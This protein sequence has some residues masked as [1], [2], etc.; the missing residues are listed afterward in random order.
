[1]AFY[2][3]S[4]HTHEIDPNYYQVNSK[5]EFKLPSNTTLLPNMRLGNLGVTA[6]D[7]VASYN[8]F[9]GTDA[10]IQ[11]IGLYDG[12]QL[13]DQCLSANI[14]ACFKNYNRDNNVNASKYRSLN[15]SG[16]GFKVQGQYISATDTYPIMETFIAQPTVNTT[17][18]T[19]KLGYLTLQQLLPFLEKSLYVPTT[20]YK[21]L[22]LVIKFE[23]DQ[24]NI[25]THTNKAPQTVRP[26]LFCNELLGDVVKNLGP[27]K[28]VQWDAVEHD[29]VV[30]P[31]ITGLGD[32]Y[33]EETEDQSITF[34]P[35]GFKN[36]TLK[37]LLM[38]NT[39]TS[40]LVYADQAD[41]TLNR[42][43]GKL[44]SRSQYKQQVQF[45]VNG[46]ALIVGNGI[47]GHNERLGYLHDTFG[48]CSSYP[49]CNQI[50]TYGVHFIN[51][52]EYVACQDYLG[53]AINE[54][55]GDLQ[56]EYK[57]TGIYSGADTRAINAISY[58]NESLNIHL[59]GEVAKA[60]V[61]NN[62]GSY[63]VL[64]V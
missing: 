52:I 11:S 18:S 26:V 63:R 16:R 42:N 53:V 60:V 17:E 44:A 28:G 20:V 49:G 56:I 19:T 8:V 59:F 12:N 27:Y 64:Y 46:R 34:N 51:D 36:K 38:V 57:R 45:V 4:I 7:N 25:L 14:W 32:D 22:K 10:L 40:I 43:G 15:G 61:M 39:P 35:H 47:T 24:V 58:Y 29:L 50:G 23:T 54:F 1:M 62:D 13:L 3:N 33:N 41:I 48:K 6:S 21:N 9:C 37:R 2:N 5:A 31:A 30:L 55:I